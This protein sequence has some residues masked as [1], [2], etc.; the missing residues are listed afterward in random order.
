M[1]NLR[2]Q[3]KEML[4]RRKLE[5]PLRFVLEKHEQ[6]GGFL[7]GSDEDPYRLRVTPDKFE[8]FDPSN[9]ERPFEDGEKMRI[10][11]FLEGYGTQATMTQRN[12][13]I[14]LNLPADIPQK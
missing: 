6:P 9:P 1:R 11:N 8:L 10:Q 4:R 14:A 7:L 13:R 12:L 3:L 2:E 5:P